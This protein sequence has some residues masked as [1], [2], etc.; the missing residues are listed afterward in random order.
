MV[1]SRFVEVGRVALINAGPD[2]GKL[3]VVVDLVDQNRAL[4]DGPCTSVCRQAINMKHLSLTD[5]KIKIGRSARS[6]PV[7]KAF[8]AAQVQDKWEQTAWARKLAM[9]K[10]RATLNDFDRFKLKL[11]KQKKNRLLR[12][13]V[14]KLKKEAKL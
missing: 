8:E 2:E 13:E 1:Y 6:G 4:I 9:R 5:F 12:T 11:A 14:K 7:K 3:C 10:K